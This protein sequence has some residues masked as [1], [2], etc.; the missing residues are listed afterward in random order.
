MTFDVCPHCGGVLNEPGAI[1]MEAESR[2]FAHIERESGELIEDSPAPTHGRIVREK[3]RCKRCGHDLREFLK[4]HCE[5]L[6]P[7][8]VEDAFEMILDVAEAAILDMPYDD[9]PEVQ[10]KRAR[11]LVAVYTVRGYL[12]IAV[13]GARKS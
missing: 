5:H 8:N 10:R 7:R 2:V 11:H 12:K 1:I 13:A 9:K 3:R 6:N 4:S